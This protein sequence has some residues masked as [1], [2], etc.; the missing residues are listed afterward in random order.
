MKSAI[1]VAAAVLLTAVVA[2]PGAAADG[3]AGYKSICFACHDAGVAGA[4]KLGDK[5]AWAPRVARGMDVLYANSINGFQG[6]TGFMPPRG[7][8]TLSDN[9]IKAVVDYMVS[10]SR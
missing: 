1:G 9:E 5:Q 3:E 10:E 4:P 2:A 6:D 8:S 7:G